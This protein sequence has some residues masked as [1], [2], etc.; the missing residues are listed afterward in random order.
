MSNTFPWFK[1][2][3]GPTKKHSIRGGGGVGGRVR[4]LGE[5]TSYLFILFS[6]FNKQMNCD[7]VR[8]ESQL[9]QLSDPWTKNKG[10]PYAKLVRRAFR[11]KIGT[12][13]GFKVGTRLQ[14]LVMTEKWIAHRPY[15]NRW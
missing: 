1:V 6:L 7:K 8:L 5:P 11:L 14:V 10:L 13:L 2:A 3:R 15:D 12:L 9:T 4:G